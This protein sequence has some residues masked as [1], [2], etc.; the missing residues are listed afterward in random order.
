MCSPAQV[1][2]DLLDNLTA[3]LAAEVNPGNQVQHNA[4][5]AKLRDEIVQAKEDLTSENARLTAERAGLDAQAQRIQANSFRL[6]LDQNVSNEI[7]RRRHRSHLPPVCTPG[8]GTSN[9]P[10][11]NW[12]EAPGA[13]APAQPRMMEPPRLNNTPP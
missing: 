9:Q 5:V 11:I 1:L 10:E 7:M 12:V 3:L 4:E 13:G 2:T 6:S 8:A